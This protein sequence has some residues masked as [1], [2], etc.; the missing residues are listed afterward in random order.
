MLGHL[1]PYVGGL[2]KLLAWPYMKANMSANQVGAFG[3]AMAVLAAVAVRLGF[4]L[5]AFVFTMIAAGTDMADGEVARANG[6]PIPEGNYLDAVGDRL[7]EGILIFGLL[8]LSPNL[9]ALALLGTCLTSF[10]KA[11]V[12]LVIIT[13]NRD[14]PGFGDHAD[15]AVILMFA[16]LFAPQIA[17]PIV[18]LM[19][20][21]WSC[22]VIRVRTALTLVRES[23][24]EKVL[25]YLQPPPIDTSDKNRQPDR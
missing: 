7:R 15:R 25:P 21:T 8:P 20:A 18:L 22:F 11:R 5:S 23:E 9:V 14:W 6:H 19:A 16:Y 13:D 12:S 10:A 4:Y 2:K 3:I 17:W 24:P 1:R